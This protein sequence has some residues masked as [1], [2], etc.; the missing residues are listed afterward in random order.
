MGVLQGALE[1]SS[2]SRNAQIIS[3]IEVLKITGKLNVASVIAL[4]SAEDKKSGSQSQDDMVSV[5]ES[6]HYSQLQSEVGAVQSQRRESVNSVASLAV[7]RI[8]P[9]DPPSSGVL[10][11]ASRLRRLGLGPPKR[12]MVA[13]SPIKDY[14]TVPRTLH[15]SVGTAKNLD[16]IMFP[17]PPRQT[18][19]HQQQM[20][21]LEPSPLS[22]LSRSR[23]NYTGSPLTS[24]IGIDD[25]DDEDSVQAGSEENKDPKANLELR[26]AK[27]KAEPS[28]GPPE[29]QTKTRAVK[30]NGKTYR[31]LH[32]IGKGGS[33]KVFKVLAPDNQVLA[34]K[35]VNLKNLD[36][37]TLT[38]Y[39]NEIELLR[40][41]GNAENIIRL[42][43]AEFNK[44][45]ANL[46]I[47]MEYGEVDLCHMLRER[48][49]KP[50]D[51]NFI[52]YCWQQMLHA[53]RI[54]HAA[55]VVHC[56]LKPANFLMVRGHLKLI[57]FGISK[58]IMNDT[59]NI[60]RE[61]QVGTVNYMSPEALQE[62]SGASAA[63]AKGII[64]IGRPS[65]VWSLGCIM[66]EMTFGKAPFANFS[67]IQ[68]LQ[69]IM[70]HGYEIEFP[71][72][73]NSALLDSIRGCL[74][75]SI[76][77]RLT[78]EALLT[79][80]FLM[81]HLEKPERPLSIDLREALSRLN[82][83]A[84]AILEASLRHL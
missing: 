25:D 75:R 16:E 15:P 72:L 46:Y 26:I 79:H 9:S 58:A 73:D 61:N 41:L 30:I 43:D 82:P 44:E 22:T 37:S 31:V 64:K 47:V 33:S 52:R 36:D 70:D 11:T 63:H 76:K 40:K 28:N 34:L 20:V 23:L 5:H 29:P 78:I 83:E 13:L 69:K 67:L 27:L 68:R 55:K 42:V 2:L 53:V 19:R 48:A 80:P 18:L 7:P 60:V 51:Y 59:T 38:G 54:V 74:E 4:P 35:K 39:V 84:R 81:P 24:G 56:D 66:Y 6:V 21:S 32:L 45:H 12:A 77:Q 8:S 3:A 62:S 49:E 10:S 50:R 57:D 17:T 65:D 1:S 71:D 14:S